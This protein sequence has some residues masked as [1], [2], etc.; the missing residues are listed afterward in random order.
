[1]ANSLTA[2]YATSDP[3]PLPNLQEF[4]TSRRFDLR[5]V[6]I[7]ESNTM[8]SSQ[9]FE[10]IR[11]QLAGLNAAAESYATQFVDALLA[12]GHQLGASD[13]HLRPT[14]EGLDVAMRIDGVLHHCGVF[15]NGQLSDVVARI[16]V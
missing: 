13:L 15:P 6:A 9:T 3:P 2:S 16:K 12:A 5:P 7:R 4:S 8:A 10:S 14:A 1:M 11:R